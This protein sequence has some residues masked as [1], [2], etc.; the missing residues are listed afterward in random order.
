MNLGGIFCFLALIA[1][2]GNLLFLARYKGMPWNV[3]A[4]IFLFVVISAI[5]GSRLYAVIFQ[6]DVF[7]SH[8]LKVINPFAGGFVYFGGFIGA[9]IGL[10]LISHLK[11]ISIFFL[12]DTLLTA[13][14]FSHAIGHI[15]C[16][17]TGGCHVLLC[18][19]PLAIWSCDAMQYPV[20]PAMILYN[21]VLYG[22]CLSQYFSRVTKWRPK[23]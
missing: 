10:F 12:S 22:V 3:V 4:D 23:Q 8:P 1:F 16:W 9:T 18:D 20:Q 14:P 15:G 17:V 21:F 7:L 6:P 19:G 2:L 13:W 11:A 5:V